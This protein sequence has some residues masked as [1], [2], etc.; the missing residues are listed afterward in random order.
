[1]ASPY[2]SGRPLSST[3]PGVATGIDTLRQKAMETPGRVVAM[4]KETPKYATGV[5]TVPLSA[6][7]WTSVKVMTDSVSYPSE[8]ELLAALRAAQKET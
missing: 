3:L 5:S 1:M 7:E 8:L 2:L 4:T 6:E